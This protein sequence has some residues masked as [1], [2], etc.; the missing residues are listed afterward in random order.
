[1]AT[2][3]IKFTLISLKLNGKEAIT[4]SVINTW[5][6][7]QKRLIYFLSYNR[8]TF[9]I[10][11]FWMIIFLTSINA[12]VFVFFSSPPLFQ[13]TFSDLC[14]SCCISQFQC[15]LVQVLHYIHLNTHYTKINLI[16]ATYTLLYLVKKTKIK[17]PFNRI[18]TEIGKA[19][20]FYKLNMLRKRKYIIH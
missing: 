1:M 12:S 20:L 7:L 5:S 17:L 15:T 3:M 13:F 19:I 4:Y 18:L 11:V 10:N 8:S 6:S 16:I 9:Q 2:K 14:Y